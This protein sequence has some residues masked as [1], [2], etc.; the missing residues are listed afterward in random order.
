MSRSYKKQAVIKNGNKERK[1]F[2]NRKYR[3]HVKSAIQKD[4]DMPQMNEIVDPYDICDNKYFA[5]KKD[6]KWYDKAKRK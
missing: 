3:R 4:E 1:Q 2:A 6:G 5:E